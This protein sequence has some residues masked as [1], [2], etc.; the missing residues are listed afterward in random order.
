MQGEVIPAA[1]VGAVAADE[2]G[3][4]REFAGDGRDGISL[5]AMDPMRSDV[6]LVLRVTAAADP[7]AGFEDSYLAAP[8]LQGTRGRDPGD[9]SANHD[10]FHCGQG[11]LHSGALASRFQAVSADIMRVRAQ[12]NPQEAGKCWPTLG[13]LKAEG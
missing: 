2:Q 10:N 6:D 8:A 9:S 5:G 13:G 1:S 12:L 7:I 4:D 11:S 3:V